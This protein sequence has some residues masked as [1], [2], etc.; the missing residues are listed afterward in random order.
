MGK[1]YLFSTTRQWNPGDEFIL[2]GSIYLMN[3]F[4]ED[5]INP[6]IFNRNPDIRVDSTH[7]NKWKTKTGTKKYEGSSFRGKGLLNAFCRLGFYDNSFKDDTNPEILDGVVFAG[8]PEWYGNRLESLYETILEYDLPTYFLGIGL[9]EKIEINQL[10]KST[11]EVL[12]RAQIIAVRDENAYQLLKSYGARKITCPAFLSAPCNKKVTEVK[13]VA[14]IYG[15]NNTVVNNWISKETHEF[16][17]ELYAKIQKEYEVGFVC[18]YIDEVEEIKKDFPNAEVYYS[19]DSKDYI[20]IYNQFD[21]VVGPRVHGIGMSASLGIPGVM[22]AHDLRADTVKG[23]QAGIINFKEETANQAISFIKDR[24]SQVS[25]LSEQL[26][27][28]KEAV[29]QEY[30]AFFEERNRK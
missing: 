10:S 5:R 22:L 13:K 15:T 17:M 16:L 6:I 2:L 11:Q 26:L 30:Q 24:I 8:S 9:G 27:R 4:C 28:H 14:L 20:E 18:H 3:Q 1:N 29:K 21:F 7:R 25:T 23:F 12:K 19:Y